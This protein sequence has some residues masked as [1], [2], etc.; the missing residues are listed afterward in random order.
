M[1]ISLAFVLM[2]LAGIEKFPRV[3]LGLFALVMLVTGVPHGA[4]DHLIYSELQKVKGHRMNWRAFFGFY[5]LTIAAYSLVWFLLPGTSLLI[6]LII[7]A[8]HFGQSQVLY[9]RWDNSSL[10]KRLL[11]LSWGTFILSTLLITHLPEVLTILSS[12]ISIPAF[13]NQLSSLNLLGIVAIPAV[14]TLV[15]WGMALREEGMTTTEL[16]REFLVIGMLLLVFN[17]AGLWMGFALYFGVWHAGSSMAAE[18]RQFQQDRKYSWKAFFR[19][20]LPFSLISLV[21]IGILGIIGWWVGD[22]IPLVLLFFIA[23]SVLTLPHTIY[24]DRFYR[25][26]PPHENLPEAK[27][28]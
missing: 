5:L 7:S 21:G 4:T 14:A 12:I 17:V 20:A 2:G 28:I 24:M 27:T 16:V 13:L 22:L 1:L 9:I 26:H 19:D 8:Y 25:S 3:E 23:I 10:K 18:I 6:F 11:N 15:L